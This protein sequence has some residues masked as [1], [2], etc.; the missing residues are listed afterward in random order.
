[1]YRL[2]FGGEISR[3]VGEA[4]SIALPSQVGHQSTSHLTLVEAVCAAFG[5]LFEG[6]RQI[7]IA[8]RI[9]GDYRLRIAK[10][11]CLAAFVLG[12]TILLTQ[13]GGRQPIAHHVALPRRPNGRRKQIGPRHLA[14][15]VLLPRRMHSGHRAGNHGQHRTIGGIS[16]VLQQGTVGERCFL[17][18]AGHELE[19]RGMVH[20]LELNHHLAIPAHSAGVGLHHA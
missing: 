3:Q 8:Y 5:N 9:T 15:A 13:Q 20:A 16:A 7:G 10:K 11:E 2:A 4:N 6:P 12:E 17:R 14:A 18:H 1:M 19:Q